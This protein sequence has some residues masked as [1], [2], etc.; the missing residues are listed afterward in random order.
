MFVDKFKCCCKKKH[1]YLAEKKSTIDA[2][3]K[4][5]EERLN[6]VNFLQDSME[7]QI[8][9]G[10]LQK[11]RHQVLIP[12]LNVSMEKNNNK[13]IDKDKEKK[14]NQSGKNLHSASFGYD[15]DDH[16]NNVQNVC[17]SDII[18]TEKK[19]INETPNDDFGESDNIGKSDQKTYIVQKNIDSGDINQG[20]IDLEISIPNEFSKQKK[21]F[22]D[23]GGGELENQELEDKPEQ[24][25]HKPINMDNIDPEPNKQ[26]TP[27]YKEMSTKIAYQQ[28]TQNLATNK[29]EE[30]VD[31]FFQD[32][33]PKDIIQDYEKHLY[34][35]SNQNI[36]KLGA[37][38]DD[39]LEIPK[40]SPIVNLDNDKDAKKAMMSEKIT[41]VSGRNYGSDWK[42][43]KSIFF[44]R[45][46]CD[47]DMNKA[48]ITH[49]NINDKGSDNGT[50]KES[51]TKTLAFI[52]NNNETVQNR[53]C[54]YDDEYQNMSGFVQDVDEGS[55][56]NANKVNVDKTG[57]SRP[58]FIKSIGFK[59]DQNDNNDDD[60]S[61]SDAS[62]N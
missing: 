4:V 52:D 35:H 60:G 18:I 24:Y 46:S 56:G 6:M 55:G 54:V 47:I 20:N 44:S 10:L 2:C 50:G 3:E 41:G 25:M 30:I 11:A 19:N 27:I 32:N 5:L 42:I 16:K 23:D 14:T 62:D 1:P 34:F 49:I 26:S 58:T 61:K 28:L 9:R 51:Q 36:K 53:E 8:I 31:K 57:N 12:L 17:N 40:H 37:R 39:S 22:D 45:D 59:I 21:T 7:F 43:T 15:S 38:I 29:L 13:K 33:Q 48:S